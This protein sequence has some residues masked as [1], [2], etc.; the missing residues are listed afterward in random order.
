MIPVYHFAKLPSTNDYIKDIYQDLRQDCIVLA[1]Q[2]TKGRGRFDRVW[3]S[4]QDLTFSVLCHE[5]DQYAILIPLAVVHALHTFGYD[6]SIKWPNDILY[7]SKKVSGILIEDMYEG[8]HRIC[9]IIGIGVNLHEH[10][11]GAYTSAYVTVSKELL[12]KEILKQWQHLKQLRVK[13]RLSLYRQ[14]SMLMGKSILLDQE[15]W[16][17]MDIDEEGHLLVEKN[18][19]IRCLRSEEI[20][21]H[22]MQGREWHDQSRL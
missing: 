12:L 3:Q 5:P 21:L 15:P 9:S 19:Q 20:T 2:Q 1:D 14:Y 8:N 17:V 11:T 6:A 13:D 18:H 4:E 22:S 16:K 7:Q 10:I